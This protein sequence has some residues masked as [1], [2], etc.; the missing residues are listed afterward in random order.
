MKKRKKKKRDTDGVVRA[1]AGLEQRAEEPV[2]GL[3]V[4][5]HDREL[6]QVGQ[7]DAAE[8]LAD[9]A[10]LAK[11]EQ[12]PLVLARLL[13]QGEAQHL[14]RVAGRRQDVVLQLDVV[15]AARLSVHH[16]ESVVEVLFGAP[17][18]PLRRVVE[19]RPQP[20]HVRIERRRRRHDF[21]QSA[22]HRLAESKDS[23]SVFFL[24]YCFTESS[25]VSAFPV[26]E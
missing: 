21:Q 6:D 17:A 25:L 13:V 2:D 16:Q 10:Q 11:V 14:G 22:L 9:E 20:R 8:H 18:H 5:E 24:F 12:E 15:G 7:V 1:E 23:Q 19:R 4:G 26:F 3:V